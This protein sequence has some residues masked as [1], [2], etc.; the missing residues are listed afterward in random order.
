MCVCVGGVCEVKMA[1][2]NSSALDPSW[3]VR[4]G[5][6]VVPASFSGWPGTC[7]STQRCLGPAGV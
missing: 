7:Q 2:H 6:E 1:D 5:C 3:A 4:W